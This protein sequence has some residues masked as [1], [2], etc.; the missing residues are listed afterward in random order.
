M[1]EGLG[2]MITKLAA[3]PTPRS[4]VAP[5]MGPTM[6]MDGGVGQ[7]SPPLPFGTPIPPPSMTAT[8]QTH[9]SEKHDEFVPKQENTGF[10]S[11]FNKKENNKV[12]N[13][14]DIYIIIN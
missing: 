4:M 7:M 8:A 12:F 1:I 14:L 11:W 2:I 5:P 10:F 3:P 6:P 13:Y 9:P